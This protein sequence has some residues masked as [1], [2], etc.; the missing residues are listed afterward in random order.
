MSDPSPSAAIPET[1]AKGFTLGADAYER[2]R[3]D[4]PAAA[5]AQL[6]E[7]LDLRPGRT[8]LDLGA[9]T[10]K[11]TR[12][13]VPSGADVI[14]VEPLAAMRAKLEAVAPTVRSLDGTAEAIP[15]PDGS[16]DAVTC[17][18]AFHWFDA[19]VAFAEL[20]RILR[21]GGLVALAWNVRDETVT[22]VRTMGDIVEELIGGEPRHQME[23]WLPEA[24]ATPFFDYLELTTTPH[25]QRLTPDGVVD[26]LGSIS[27]VAAASAEDRAR[28]EARVRELL[29]TDPVTAGRA[30]ILLPY[31]T[32]LHWLRR[33]DEPGTAA[34]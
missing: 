26:R 30:E 23:R 28:T 1:A 2:S 24:E 7:R 16:V 33:I 6:V 19:P 10:G 8:V 22:W 14:A 18:Q 21:P 32:K 17:A 34:A 13:L 15:V 29:A 11:L 20:H 9:G 27:V 3:P 25:A 31:T 5:V 4:Y 12:L